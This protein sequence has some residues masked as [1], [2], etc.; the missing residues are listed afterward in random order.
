MDRKT[1]TMDVLNKSNLPEKKQSNPLIDS[2]KSE[3]MM[4]LVEGLLP[5]I[6]PFIT[7]ALE[8][9]NEYFGDDEK[10]F[11][12]KRIRGEVK[13]IV[14]NNV[15]GEYE[16]GRKIVKDGDNVETIE[17]PFIIDKSSIIAVHDINSFIESLLS[18]QF[19]IEK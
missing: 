10:I 15:A 6:Q 19:T 17:T 3:M 4:G 18:G 13:V 8:K 2:L 9:L 5:Q 14:I 11:V 12:M 7:P 1:S 16:I